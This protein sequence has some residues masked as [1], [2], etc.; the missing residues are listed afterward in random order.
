MAATQQDKSASVAAKGSGESAEVAAAGGTS[1]SANV[2]GSGST[3]GRQSAPGNNDKASA[4]PGSP[5][6]AAVASGTS[7]NNASGNI[8]ASQQKG[9]ESL[10]GKLER[11]RIESKRAVNGAQNGG[12]GPIGHRGQNGQSDKWVA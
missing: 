5:N 10:S 7:V 1:P 3:A 12:M 11:L 9:E 8:S 2:N 4:T 6:A